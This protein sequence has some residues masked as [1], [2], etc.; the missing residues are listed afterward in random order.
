M[1]GKPGNSV[2]WRASQAIEEGKEG[3]YT[4]CTYGLR[5]QLEPAGTVPTERSLAGIL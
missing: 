2:L 3:V 1:E 5:R 4:W